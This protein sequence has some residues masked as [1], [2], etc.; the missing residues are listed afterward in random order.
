MFSFFKNRYQKNNKLNGSK[1]SI[2]SSSPYVVELINISKTYNNGAIIANKNLTIKVRKN[3]IHALVGENGAGK[4]TIMSILFGSTKPDK[5]KILVKGVQ[6]N[7]K[8]SND[9]AKS[10]IGMVHQHFKLINNFTAL[11]NIIL[12]N[13][14]TKFGFINRYVA[15]ERIKELCKKYNL[16]INL[17]QKVISS[18]VS[19][20]QRIEIL[21]LLYRDVEILIFDEPTAVL[22]D[23]EIEGFLNMLKNFKKMKKTVILITHKLNEVKSVADYATI[24]RKGEVV[25]DIQVSQYSEKQIAT[26]MV[27]KDIPIVKKF[28]SNKKNENKKIICDIKNLSAYKISQP[29]VL[30]LNN[31]NLTLYENEIVGL[32]GI[33]GNGQTELALII[34]GIL[35]NVISGEV[36]I[37]DL[38]TNKYI[39]AINENVETLNECGVSHVPEDRL[40]YGIIGNETV[41][42]NSVL[43]SINKKPFTRL[44]FINNKEIDKY[45]N[46]V[47]ANWDIRGANNGKTLAA[48]LS[49]GN[50]QKLVIGRELTKKH[51]LLILVQPTRGLDFGA[52]NLIHQKIVDDV[53]KN[54]TCVLLISYEL[55]EILSI[56]SRI[57]IIDN[58]QIVYD[59]SSSK[60]TR[61]IIGEYLAKSQSIQ[62]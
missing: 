23:H 20:Q 31:F 33:E 55:N 61:Q 3:T 27:G 59:E 9:A 37:Y 47:I 36:K 39:N 8:S 16:M 17:D 11:D 51:N 53:R 14:T 42:I 2:K 19:E 54:H 12:G 43:T 56:S 13:E 28:N 30:A 58:G 46:R 6:K 5:G 10:G 26:A 1:T 44:G 57:A 48:K 32:A 49:G 45:A 62:A 35:K 52:I 24:I 7:F 25:K 18:T 22:S 21:K 60:T 29:N 50:Q 15:R 4:S 40:K 34:G 41:S 38:N